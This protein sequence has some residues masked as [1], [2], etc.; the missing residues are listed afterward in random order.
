M[1]DPH[2]RPSLGE[3]LFG[4][5]PSRR[6]LLGTAGLGAVG[7]ALGSQVLAGSTAFAADGAAP[8]A[9]VP[10]DDVPHTRTWMSWPSRKSVWGRQLGGVQDDIALIARTIARYEPVVMC[11]PDDYS[12]REAQDACGPSVSVIGSIPTDDLWMRDIAPVFRRDGRGGLQA[13]GLNF[14]GWGRKQVHTDDAH[15]A[16]NVAHLTG[17]P[18]VRAD[19]VGEGG[20]I[21]TDGDGTVMA[22]ESSLVNK[23]RNRGWSRDEVEAAVLDA[24]GADRMI[25]VPGIKGKDITDDHIDV[26]SR[27]VRP[28]VVLVQLPPDDRDDAWARDAREQFAVLSGATDARGRRLRVIRVDGPDTVRS[29]RS[30]FVDSYLNFHV[31]NGAV[32]AAQFGDA[33]KD[34]AAKR[35]LEAAFPG[36]E[37]IQLDVD[38]LMAGGG[39]IHC[40]TMQEPL[41]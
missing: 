41:P 10:S 7:L 31:V 32:I 20:G 4:A 9:R 3:R 22:T 29:R 26:T 25:W 24:Y 40:S 15:V 2:A 21:E 19:F 13:V 36:R 16:E 14:N 27:F 18:F 23:N 38:R 6:A 1:S 35:T 28:G 17:L 39:G 30:D 11:A 34:A 8:R 12:V 33:Y 37:V 5:A